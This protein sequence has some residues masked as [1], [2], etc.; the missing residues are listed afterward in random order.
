MTDRLLVRTPEGAVFSFSLASPLVRMIAMVVDLMAISAAW[1]V[2]VQFLSLAAAIS[3][4]VYHFVEI[5]GYFVLSQGYFLVMEG[6]YGGRTL[7]KALCRL[8][9]VDAD[10]LRLS[11]SQVIV[12]SVLR[13]VDGLPA[14]YLVGGVSALLSPRAQRLG[15]LAAGTVVVSEYSEKMPDAWEVQSQ[16]FN[17]LRACS[18]ASARLRY[19]IGPEEAA[20]AARALGRR[21]ALEDSARA[22]IFATMAERFRTAAALPPEAVEGL[23]DEQLT[24]NVVSILLG[25]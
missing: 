24:R 4:D 12:R 10:G 14:F 7:G 22:E 2:L 5:V 17:S 18:G 1:S 16:M 15:D 21:D 20:L 9:V 8:R 19:A 13:F 3:T 23:T 6:A 25:R 11:W